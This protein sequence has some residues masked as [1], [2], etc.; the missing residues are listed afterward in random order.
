MDKLIEAILYIET[1]TIHILRSASY[2]LK[3]KALKYNEKAAECVYADGKT[4]YI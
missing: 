3:N 2:K 4:H 1:L